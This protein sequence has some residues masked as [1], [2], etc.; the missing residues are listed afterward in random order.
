MTISLQDARRLRGRHVEGGTS[1]GTTFRGVLLN[2]TCRQAWIVDGDEDLF[3]A[4]ADISALAE[5]APA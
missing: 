4:L 5:A 2:A 1:D 3:V